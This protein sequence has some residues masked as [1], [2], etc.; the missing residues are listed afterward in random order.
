MQSIISIFDQN[1][2][3]TKEKMVHFLTPVQLKSKPSSFSLTFEPLKFNT[4]VLSQGTFHKKS[5]AQ[6]IS[7]VPVRLTVAMGMMRR[8]GAVV[9]HSMISSQHSSC[10]DISAC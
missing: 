8:R 2:F 9:R 7:D 10:W 5:Q 3:S 4:V 1:L 6:D